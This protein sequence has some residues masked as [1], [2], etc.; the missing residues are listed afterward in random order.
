MSVAVVTGESHG[1]G[2]EIARGLRVLGREV[3]KI[4]LEKWV[5]ASVSRPSTGQ[6]VRGLNPFKRTSQVSLV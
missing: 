1:L 2:F 4:G 5:T 3:E 6:K